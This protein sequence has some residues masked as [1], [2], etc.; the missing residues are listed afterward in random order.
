MHEFTHASWMRMMRIFPDVGF[1]AIF[2][3]NKTPMKL[4]NIPGPLLSYILFFLEDMSAA[5]LAKKPVG[6]RICL[7]NNNKIERGGR[8]EKKVFPRESEITIESIF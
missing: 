7:R 1:A 8:P 4:E 2:F 5:N 3:S 6:E